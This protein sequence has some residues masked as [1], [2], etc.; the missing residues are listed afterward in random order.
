MV[1][2]CT[3]EDIVTVMDGIMPVSRVQIDLGSNESLTVE[4]AR[5]IVFDRNG[6]RVSNTL[7]QVAAE[8][9]SLENG[10]CKLT[11]ASNEFQARLGTNHIY[12]VLNEGTGGEEIVDRLNS[13]STSAEMEEIRRLSVNYTGLLEVEPDK[14]PAFLMCVHDDVSVASGSS[15]IDITGLDANSYGFSMRRTMAKVVL[16]SI[17]GGVKPDGKILGTEISYNPN[18][19]TDQTGTSDIVAIDEN[20]NLIGGNV[21]LAGT[22]EIF[23]NKIELLN[24]P[25]EYSWIQEKEGS[26]VATAYS[27]DYLPAQNISSGFTL[28]NGYLQR[29]WPGSIVANGLIDFSRI[30]RFPVFYKQEANKGV[31]SYDIQ[32][33]YPWGE[34][35]KPNPK[36]DDA[37][38]NSGNF[39]PWVTALYSG[40]RIIEGE[41]VP[42]LGTMRLTSNINPAAWGLIGNGLSYYIPENIAS[43]YS[44]QTMIRVYFSIGVVTAEVDKQEIQK[45]ISESLSQ[46]KLPIIKEDGSEVVING[47]D[48][49]EVIARAKLVVNPAVND[50]NDNEVM[51]DGKIGGVAIVGKK[52][53]EKDKYWGIC[54]DGI[55]AIWHGKDVVINNQDGYYYVDT[56][57]TI[58]NLYVDVPLNNY[59]ASSNTG[60]N[61]HN[62]YR[63]REYKVKL[64][65]TKQGGNW[66]SSKSSEA[67]SRSF[68][69]GSEEFIVTSSVEVSPLID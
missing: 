5:V 27:G 44:K 13:V 4:T 14:E 68:Q 57:N 61:D 43:D 20:G 50:P 10:A 21:Q 9:F 2:A 29:V 30:D 64:F 12:V 15:P 28:D 11:L 49:S 59:D 41:V 48:V 22:S 67:A 45:I 65:V 69:I 8:N 58:S 54:Y 60:S 31:D 38:F 47:K 18:S 55:N 3:Q 33:A 34:S 32:P 23:V 40:N 7:L 37:E 46:D 19:V 25:N 35:E 6:K 26:Q 52:P 51:G 56:N 1:S 16:E 62:I 66:P 17:W 53:E 42:N 24:V 39:I 36:S 63:G